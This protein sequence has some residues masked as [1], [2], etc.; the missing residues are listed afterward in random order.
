MSAFLPCNIRTHTHTHSDY[1]SLRRS[2]TNG[3]RQSGEAT[4]VFRERLGY[5]E[6]VERGAC[7][8]KRAIGCRMAAGRG[9]AT[10][11]KDCDGA[12][13]DCRLAV[14]TAPEKDF[15]GAWQDCRM[16]TRRD[17]DARRR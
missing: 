15:D 4:A 5:R 16:V 1:E 11:E 7:L 12:W 13:Q 8:G 2:S 14:G 10:P 9:F 17:W 3:Y 6:A